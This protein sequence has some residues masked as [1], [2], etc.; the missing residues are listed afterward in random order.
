MKLGIVA[1]LLAMPVAASADGYIFVNKHDD[2]Y[3]VVRQVA[4]SPR[5]CDPASPATSCVP[6]SPSQFSYRD[7]AYGGG[8]V[9]AAK[10]PHHGAIDRNR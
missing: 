7:V 5:D 6:P 3:H 10:N 4:G 1:L 9:E 8:A 2:S